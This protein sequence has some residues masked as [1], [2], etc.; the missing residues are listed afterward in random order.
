MPMPITVFI[1]KNGKQLV[2]ETKEWGLNNTQGM[3]NALEFADLNEDGYLDIIGGNV[4]EN[5]KWKATPSRPVRI[6][7]DDFDENG[8]LDPIIFYDFFDRYVPFAS[9][10]KLTQQLSYLKKRFPDYQTFSEIQGIKNLTGKT[11]TEILT[12]RE[13]KELRSMVFLNSKTQFEGIPLPTKA[14]QSAIQDFTY[15]PTT[16]RLYFV[17]NYLNYVVELGLKSANSGGFLYHF[18]NETNQFESYQSLSLP[19][20]INAREIKS[21]GTTKWIVTLNN[22]S[23]V[24]LKK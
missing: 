10:D 18:N 23:P 8:Q 17:G 19:K 20:G 21:L 2:D 6:Y 1:N 4:G 16:K 9:K 11:K 22:A 3:W 7:L 14:Q 15:D 13:I 5:F 24:L 12:Y